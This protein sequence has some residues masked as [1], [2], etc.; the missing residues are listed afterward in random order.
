[1]ESAGSS[2]WTQMS[3][4]MDEAAFF[5]TSLGYARAKGC[6]APSRSARREKKPIEEE[7]GP[8]HTIMG[9]GGG[10]L[11][12]REKIHI[13]NFLSLYTKE[14]HPPTVSETLNGSPYFRTYVDLDFK[15]P[16]GDTNVTLE[17]KA[18]LVAVC[19]QAL[20]KFYSKFEEEGVRTDGHSGASIIFQAVCVSRPTKFKALPTTTNNSRSGSTASSGGGGGGRAAVAAAAA[21]EEQND[22][23][24]NCIASDG[25][26]II[27]PRVILSVEQMVYV[28]TSMR[29]AVREAFGERGPGCN[30]WDDVFD[31]Q[32]YRNGLRMIGC[33]KSVSCPTCS[34][35]RE[36]ADDELRNIV[37]AEYTTTFYKE[38][39]AHGDR[40]K[41]VAAASNASTL[42]K[43]A[44]LGRVLGQHQLMVAGQKPEM[45]RTLIREIMKR[46]SGSGGGKAAAA[47]AV[48]AA[49]SKDTVRDRS[50]CSL[51]HGRGL[52]FDNCPYSVD[53]VMSGSGEL[54]DQETM[55]LKKDALLAL[56]RCSIRKPDFEACNPPWSLYDGCTPPTTICGVAGGGGGRKRS[57]GGGGTTGGKMTSG[58]GVGDQQED[59]VHIL[60]HDPRHIIIRSLIHGYDHRFKDVRLDKIEVGVS[61]FALYSSGGGGNMLLSVRR[62]KL[63][64]GG[65]GGG[66]GINTSGSTMA[67]AALRNEGSGGGGSGNNPRTYAYFAH[68]AGPGSGSCLNLNRPH[69]H[70]NTKV[71]FA[72]TPTFV[73][74][75]CMNASCKPDRHAGP[76]RR[77][78]SSPRITIPPAISAILFPRGDV[79]RSA[80]E[81]ATLST[82]SSAQSRHDACVSHAHRSMTVQKLFGKDTFSLGI[83]PSSSELN[84]ASTPTSASASRDDNISSI[85]GGG[86]EAKQRC[87][88]VCIPSLFQQVVHGRTRSMDVSGV[89]GAVAPTTLTFGQAPF[90]H[91]R[92]SRFA[93][94]QSSSPSSLS[95]PAPLK[96][97]I[98]T[99]GSSASKPA[100]AKTPVP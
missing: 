77:W 23:D 71:Y 58:S 15:G 84:V 28:L 1:M 55:V 6:W 25:V 10:V 68:A 81:V 16:P 100:N 45:S 90:A 94:L 39:A 53:F 34:E 85:R 69:P 82:S 57:R 33:C 63:S 51:C 89:S 43:E 93:T 54:D 5:D 47:S 42:A 35:V 75:R 67:S 73:A 91:G 86:T 38:M 19:T 64:T 49:K 52:I 80:R 4:R 37:S 79:A 8:D 78:N 72:I 74:Q 21:G 13:S 95:Q 66:G 31:E 18:R 46:I 99:T 62:R 41:A 40:R 97:R 87:E 17:L 32:V 36:K 65:G 29:E 96:I 60:A 27:W 14:R 11:Y 30:A 83:R 92:A 24:T 20:R 50:E 98:N 26:H 88:S 48:V 3:N 44:F 12:L 61:P 56:R 9:P 70:T 2:Q 76:C 59:R 7:P 22:E